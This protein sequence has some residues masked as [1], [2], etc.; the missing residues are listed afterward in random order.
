MTLKIKSSCRA[1][2]SRQT[3]QPTPSGKK[4]QTYV[5]KALIDF[6]RGKQIHAIWDRRLGRRHRLF[7]ST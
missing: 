1:S 6:T 5:Q 4:G 7:P 2:A 3:T